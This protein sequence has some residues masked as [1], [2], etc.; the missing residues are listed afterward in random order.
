[1][2]KELIYIVDPMCSWCWGFA[3]VMSRVAQ[4]LNARVGLRV[5]PGGLRLGP[6]GPMGDQMAKEIM[7][8]WQDVAKRTGQ[9][10]SLD[11]PLT[12]DF[13]YDTGPACMA[14]SAMARHMPGMEIAYLHQL[15]HAFYVERRDTASLDVLLDCAAQCGIIP[16][17][18]SARLTMPETRIAFEADLEMVRGWGVDGFPAVLLRDGSSVKALTIGYQEYAALKPRLAAWLSS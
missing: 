12:G 4:D 10:F 1:M 14:L 16:A 13:V 9:A 3:P 2:Q 18:L 11:V 15:H 17:Q 6:A 7:H 8:H 5:L